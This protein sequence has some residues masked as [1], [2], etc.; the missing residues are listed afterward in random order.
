MIEVIGLA[1]TAAVLAA[2]LLLMTGKLAR[3]DKRFLLLNAC[4]SA[5]I[6]CSLVFNFNPGA[7]LIEAAWLAIS[8][9][10]LARG[11]HR[12]GAQS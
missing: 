5:G 12:G 10:G 4:G 1:G 8:L 9:Y 11:V 2:Y 7:L 3:T 6:V